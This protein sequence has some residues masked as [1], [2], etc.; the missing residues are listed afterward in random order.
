M[1]QKELT[2]SDIEDKE[3]VDNITIQLVKASKLLHMEFG[4]ISLYTEVTKINHKNVITQYNPCGKKIKTEQKNV[5]LPH[6]YL[7]LAI[8]DTCKL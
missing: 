1:K 6:F 7:I 8:R 2:L 3:P 4:N 5:L